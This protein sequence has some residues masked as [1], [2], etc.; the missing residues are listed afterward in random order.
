MTHRFQC[1]LTLSTV[2]AV[3]F[4][5]LPAGLAGASRAGQLELKLEAELGRLPPAQSRTNNPHSLP[6]LL[7]TSIGTDPVPEEH[8]T[9]L[10]RVLDAVSTKNEFLAEASGMPGPAQASPDSTTESEAR[11]VALL[12][13]IESAWEAVSDVE[14]DA[15][16]PTDVPG[17]AAKDTPTNT[18][19][20]KEVDTLIAFEDYEQA[21]GLLNELLDEAPD[22][23]EYRLRLLHVLSSAG[24]AEASAEQEKILSAM[25]DGPL[26]ET[27][28]RVRRLGHVLM[29]GHPLFQDS[30]EHEDQP[31]EAAFEANERVFDVTAPEGSVLA[32]S[33]SD[34]EVV[35]PDTEESFDIEEDDLGDLIESPFNSGETEHE[36]FDVLVDRLLQDET[37]TDEANT[38]LAGPDTDKL[39]LDKTVFMTLP[40]DDTPKEPED[41]DLGQT[42]FK[43]SKE[44]LGDLPDD[45]PK[46]P[47]D[48]DLGQTI[49]KM[50]RSALG[51]PPEKE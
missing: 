43:L 8:R 31:Q 28:A 5:V 47:E 36:E 25:M 3:Q 14:P 44:A 27:L 39:D 50:P 10:K 30:A 42:I 49:F 1:L 40:P 34:H 20:L 17:L 15:A 45:T 51:I 38:S 2:I 12:E 35:A 32:A 18:E 37:E 29:P 48:D 11:E 21:S 4:L 7:V 16:E 46:K 13:E 23:P 6:V 24:N 19:A 26:S 22:N 33:D 9:R 41:D